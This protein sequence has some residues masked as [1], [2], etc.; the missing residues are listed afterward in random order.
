MGPRVVEMVFE[1]ISK[2][3]RSTW[4]LTRS[5]IG[6]K[7]HRL[8]DKS[9]DLRKLTKLGNKL[10]DL[11]AWGVPGRDL[12]AWGVIWERK[13]IKLGDP[14]FD[15]APDPVPDRSQIAQIS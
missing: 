13:L 1:I 4:P 15:P 5:R 14:P 2:G 8:A 12:R 10:M 7:L 9:S 6:A 11:R 3:A